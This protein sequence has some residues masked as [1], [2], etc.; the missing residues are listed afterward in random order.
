MRRVTEND[1]AGALKVL[2]DREL[3]TL[4]TGGRESVADGR[5]AARSDNISAWMRSAPDGLL[6]AGN[7]EMRLELNRLALRQPD[8]RHVPVDLHLSP[9]SRLVLLAIIDR[10]VYDDGV[11][12]SEISRRALARATDIER[13]VIF[14]H[15]IPELET[16]GYLVRERATQS[17]PGAFRLLIP[18]FER[19]NAVIQ[20]AYGD[21][22]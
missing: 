14:S 19:L 18:T 1:W 2:V 5:L 13:S 7:A 22:T 21:P 17:R 12:R 4:S 8:S 16:A 15:L 10:C 6:P 3:G 9:P 20:L 11:V